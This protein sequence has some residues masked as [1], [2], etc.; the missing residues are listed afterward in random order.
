MAPT[1]SISAYRSFS[2]GAVISLAGVI[3]AGIISYLTRRVMTLKLS[4]EEYGFFYGAFSFVSLGLAVVDLGLAK[5]GTVLMAK[6]AARGD[7][8]T[9]NLFFSI[10]F[11]IKLSSS[12]LVGILVWF[13]SPILVQN[14][15]SF[16][17]GLPTMRCLALFIPLQTLGGLAIGSLEAMQ[18]FGTRTLL[19]TIYYAIVLALVLLLTGSL[20]T[21]APALAYCAGAIFLLTGIIHLVRRHDVRMVWEIQ[22]WRRAW[23]ET[24]IYA[25]W[26]T[27]SVV[28]LGT[29]NYIDTLML[30]RLSDLPSVAGYQVALP[31]AQIGRSLIFLPVVFMPIAAAL[32]QRGQ[33]R[34]LQESCNFITLLMCFGSGSA[35]LLLLPL[36]GNLISL[37]FDERYRWAAS[38]LVA[39]GSGMPLL[40]LAEFYLNTLCGMEKPRPAAAAA[41]LGLFVNVVAN[42]VF[43]PLF[44]ALGAALATLLS[45]FLA[46]LFAW[47][48]LLRKL[49]FRPAWGPLLILMLLPWPLALLFDLQVAP[50]SSVAWLKCLSAW[51]LYGACGFFLLSAGIVA[52]R[53]AR[54]DR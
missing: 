45:Y 21:L 28:A 33:W 10:I 43:I 3:A 11:I 36:A 24:W 9:V 42:L 52:L 51:V 32:W 37:L 6:Y 46:A 38:S 27:L 40:V 31:L 44:G 34:Q 50:A 54:P 41:G 2:R 53:P 20:K 29:M 19:Q 12:V 47:L 22:K 14:Y 8:Q 16:P 17:G 25:R 18:D 5:T 23:P 13:W 7:R 4:P 48:Y 15:F 30:T 39:L 26:L 1:S 35:F 49:A